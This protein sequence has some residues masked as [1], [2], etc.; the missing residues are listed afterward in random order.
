MLGWRTAV[1]PAGDGGVCSR[2]RL[3]VSVYVCMYVCI[4]GREREGGSW[5][6]S[7]TDSYGL[8][9]KGLAGAPLFTLEEMEVLLVE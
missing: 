5:L 6:V 4:C 1:H 9:G 8:G 2:L 7:C 3:T